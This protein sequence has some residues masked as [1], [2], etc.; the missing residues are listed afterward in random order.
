MNFYQQCCAPRSNVGAGMAAG[1]SG[2][3]STHRGAAIRQGAKV[4]REGLA[5]LPSLQDLVPAI[6]SVDQISG[7][8]GTFRERFRL[9]R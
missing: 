5:P 2:I 4:R 1:G 6:D 7:W 3:R 8:V 9:S